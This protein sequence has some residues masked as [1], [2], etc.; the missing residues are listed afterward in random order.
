MDLLK[1]L[2][3]ECIIINSDCKN[4]DEILKTIANVAKRD[5]ILSDISEYDIFTKL[6]IREKQGSTGFGNK[7]AIPHIFIEGISD[8]VIGIITVPKGID[9]DSLDKKKTHLFVFIIGPTGK[10]NVYIRYLSGISRV[11]HDS[12]TVNNIINA[13]TASVLK[14]TF[15]KHMT[16]LDLKEITKE[17]DFFQIYIQQE[18]LFLDIIKIL[19]EIKN[20]N[21][22]VLEANDVNR[23]LFS[24]PLFSSFWTNNQK[25]FHRL[26]LATV[27]KTYS[28][29]VLKQINKIIDTLKDS[30]GVLVLMQKIDYIKGSLNF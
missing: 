6:H 19:S 16:I 20:V 2:K 10:E 7:I 1:A 14:E 30:T 12:A 22:S 27:D 8:F 24:L 15:L 26:V 18:D 13:K 25:G 28:K 5:P 4:K 23:Y 29:E 3:E 11:L 9:F 21:I 17:F